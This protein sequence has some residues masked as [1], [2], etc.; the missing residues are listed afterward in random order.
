M[1][2]RFHTLKGMTLI[3]NIIA[4]SLIIAALAIAGTGYYTAAHYVTEGEGYQDAAERA[5]EVMD[6]VH[7]VSYGS[8]MYMPNE[9]D[10]CQSV[11]EIYFDDKGKFRTNVIYTDQKIKK[12]MADMGYSYD[13]ANDYYVNLEVEDGT[14][15]EYYGCLI[16]I[17]SS[18]E[19]TNTTSITNDG[20]KMAFT[21]YYDPFISSTTEMGR[22]KNTFRCPG[23]YVYVAAPTKP[24]WFYA[25]VN[26]DPGGEGV[27]NAIRNA[28]FVPRA[29]F[30][31]GWPYKPY[32]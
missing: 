12:L 5:Q 30:I 8:E 21:G 29:K 4:F 6:S 19:S 28:E 24:G 32:K 9:I 2:K 13:S 14:Y 23:V 10:L 16:K 20:Y 26:E 17:I 1:K 25:T 18:N 3:E 22:N 31:E 27:S 7:R 11:R 15:G